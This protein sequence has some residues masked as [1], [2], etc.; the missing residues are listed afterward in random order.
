MSE[1]R[2]FYKSNLFKSVSVCLI[3]LNI[4]GSPISLF[5]GI[6]SNFRDAIDKQNEAF[7]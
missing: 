5:N 6:K 1:V 3:S 4:I 2:Q 7:N